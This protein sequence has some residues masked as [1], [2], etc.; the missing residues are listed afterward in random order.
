MVISIKNSSEEG[1]KSLPLF[2]S[3]TNSFTMN[4][5]EGKAHITV[6]NLFLIG[7]TKT[8]ILE[9]WRDAHNTYCMITV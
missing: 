6:S 5:V 8:C 2:E 1:N 3:K 7:H 4:L 9:W